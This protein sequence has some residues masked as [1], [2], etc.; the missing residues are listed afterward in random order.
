MGYGVR[1]TICVLAVAERKG[2]RVREKDGGD[3]IF[4]AVSPILNADQT[5]IHSPG[6]MKVFWE[7]YKVSSGPSKLPKNPSHD[8]APRFSI[9]YA[10]YLI[11]PNPYIPR[12]LHTVTMKV[13]YFAPLLLASLASAGNVCL[14]SSLKPSTQDENFQIFAAGSPC[15][16][17]RSKQITLDKDFC[18]TL[19]AGFKICGQNANLVKSDGGAVDGTDCGVELEINGKNYPG[20]RIHM[21]GEQPPAGN[22]CYGDCGPT[23]TVTIFHGKVIF[24]G[25]PMCD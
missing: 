22:P 1:C 10:S 20:R 23:S 11:S 25:V 9:S 24:E 2:G 7:A 18:D 19:P 21:I 6:E 8:N 5:D 14:S 3:P 4:L 17:D 16:G 12:T 15:N 13:L